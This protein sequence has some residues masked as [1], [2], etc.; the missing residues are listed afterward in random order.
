MFFGRFGLNGWF[1][2]VV[3]CML[4]DELVVRWVDWFPA[5]VDC[6]G[7]FFALA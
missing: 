7:E 4:V 6:S 2:W 1:Y 5:M 3:A